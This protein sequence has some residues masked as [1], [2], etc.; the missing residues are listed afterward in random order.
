VEFGW[1]KVEPTSPQEIKNL[2]DIISRGLKDAKV[3]AISDDLRLIAAFNAALTAA[4]V[5]LRAC[6]YRV[7]PQQG[8]HMKMIDTMEY[9][10]K[11]DTSLIRKMRVISKRRNT[12]SYDSAG[13]V[14]AQELEQA[15]NVADELQQHV[16]AWLKENHPRLL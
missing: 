14:S 8:H 16:T 6:G 13:S 9:T 10:L 7:S 4:S 5:A 15:I 1:L 11:S 2:L 3:E 12:T